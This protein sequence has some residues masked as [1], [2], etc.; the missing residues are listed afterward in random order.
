MYYQSVQA[1]ELLGILQA[2]PSAGQPLIVVGDFNSS[3]D[4]VPLAPTVPTPYVQ[5]IMAGFHD[6]WA[7]RP[8]TLAG[9]TCCQ[10]PDLLNR[11]SALSQRIDLLFAFEYPTKVRH[12]EVL[13][14]TAAAKTPP[15][16]DRLWPSDHG[17]LIGEL[18]F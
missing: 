12:A 9:Y 16:G 5:F 2:T 13:G 15:P 7:L 1:M 4:D 18:Q 8:G 11:H 6:A 17:A 3:P 10:A 14:T